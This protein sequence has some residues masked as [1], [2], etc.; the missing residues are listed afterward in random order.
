MLGAKDGAQNLT[1]LSSLSRFLGE[2]R[3]RSDC[4]HH[5]TGRAGTVDRRERGRE[6]LC[7]QFIFFAMT[8]IGD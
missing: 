7:G 5:A 1:I 2:W 6:S 3:V 4:H 8:N